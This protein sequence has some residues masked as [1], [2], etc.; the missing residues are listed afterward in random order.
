MKLVLAAILFLLLPAPA[1]AQ[2]GTDATAHEA[3]E[4]WP[5]RDVRIIVPFAPGDAAD[6]EAR[7]LAAHFARVFGVGFVV[8]NR[9]GVS[10]RMG[11]ELSFRTAADGYTLTMTGNGP[12]T[13]LPQMMGANYDPLVSFEPILLT[14]AMPMLLLAPDGPAYSSLQ[15]LVLRARGIRGGLAGCSTGIATPSHMAVLLFARAMGVDVIHV[16]Y[17]G[18]HAAL[19]DVMGARCDILFDD[20]A[21]AGRHARAGRVQA[22]GVTTRNPQSAWP[23]VPALEGVTMRTW[24][25]LVAPGGTHRLIVAQLNDEGRRFAAT[26]AERARVLAEGGIPLDLGP[27]QIRSFMR[28]EIANWAELLD[29]LD[30]VGFG[31]GASGMGEFGVRTTGV[32]ARQRGRD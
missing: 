4:H 32:R 28:R 13:L 20:A 8:D 18:S 19:T 1:P 12:L 2:W 16:P 25:A 15:D 17:R 11:T 23:G 29:K 9:A 10:G 14:A 31:P 26:E 30:V 6:A 22:L 5:R 3:A 7:R 24:T 27:S 21:S